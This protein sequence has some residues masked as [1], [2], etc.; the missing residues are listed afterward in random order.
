[1]GVLMSSIAVREMARMTRQMKQTKSPDRIGALTKPTQSM[2]GPNLV[3][4][5]SRGWSWKEARKKVCH[6]FKPPKMKQNTIKLMQS[7]LTLSHLQH[8]IEAPELRGNIS[9]EALSFDNLKFALSPPLK[10]TVTIIN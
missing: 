10:L 2:A 8:L 3:S 1:M 5:L 9:P 7:V 6:Q 4:P